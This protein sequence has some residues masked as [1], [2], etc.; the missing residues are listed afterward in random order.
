[1]TRHLLAF[2]AA[3]AFGLVA[4]PATAP[5]GAPP[6][7]A[8]GDPQAPRYP[9]PPPMPQGHYDDGAPFAHPLPP[10]VYPAPYP[11]PAR[12]YPVGP[13][14]YQQGPMVWH[15]EEGPAYGSGSSYWYAYQSAGAPC[16]CPSYSWVRVPI[17][18]HYRYSAPLRH[19][20][21]VVEQKVV[22][23]KVVES[24]IV[25]AAPATKYVKSAPAKITKGKV[26][27]TAK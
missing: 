9:G 23:E 27:R 14:P 22:R 7:P 12:P 16:G 18:T 25:S 26:V 1:M 11:E 19:V 4:A 17:E 13:G 21:E 8:W 5:D 20:A 3:T 24:K 2:V 15:G 6:P 10:G